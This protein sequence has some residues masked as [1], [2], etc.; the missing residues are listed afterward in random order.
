MIVFLHNSIKKTWVILLIN[1]SLFLCAC[2]KED[3]SFNLIKKPIL[4]EL[5]ITSNSLSKLK[6]TQYYYQMGTMR[7]L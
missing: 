3:F 7:I 6:L 4:S 5:S 2:K 1:I